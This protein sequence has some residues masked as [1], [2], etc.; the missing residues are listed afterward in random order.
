MA[1]QNVKSS[2][3]DVFMIAHSA[4][5]KVSDA[6]QDDHMKNA[7]LIGMPGKAR[8]C[9]TVQLADNIFMLDQE[10][11]LS[12]DGPKKKAVGGE[13]RIVRAYTSAAFEGKK[14]SSKFPDNMQFIPGPNGV[15]DFVKNSKT[16]FS[17]FSTSSN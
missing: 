10:I 8:Y 6:L 1:I 9:A 15:V 3:L 4:N 2:G 13:V 12:G 11:Q 5:Y 17:S 14:R 7:P 16:F